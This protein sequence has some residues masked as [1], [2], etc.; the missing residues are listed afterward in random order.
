MATHRAPKQWK[1][2]PDET[3]NSVENWRQNLMYILSLDP[4]FA[5]FLGDGVEWQ[6]KSAAHPNRGLLDDG[7]SVA[8]TE[9]KTASQKNAILELM[10]GQIANYTG[11][12]SR[13]TIVRQSTSLDFIWQKIREHY[14]FQSTGAH[15]LDLA[16]ILAPNVTSRV[17][18]IARSVQLSAIMVSPG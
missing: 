18:S 16:L 9:R 2:T 1:L 6:P 13:N 7:D 3:V 14:C 4:H 12:I 11:V 17:L 10:L 8:E 5:P 15:F